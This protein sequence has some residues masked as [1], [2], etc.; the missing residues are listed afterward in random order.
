MTQA[1]ENLKR[2]LIRKDE[3]HSTQ[4]D[5]EKIQTTRSLIIGIAHEVNTP[6]G[7]ALTAASHA[8]LKIAD[9][10]SWLEKGTSFSKT[11]LEKHLGTINEGLALNVGNLH[12]ASILLDRFK[13]VDTNVHQEQPSRVSL[14]QFFSDLE[15]ALS[16]IVE[17]HSI[18]VY[19]TGDSIQIQ[20]VALWRVLMQLVENS[21]IHGFSEQ[22]N[23]LINI[24]A[25]VENECLII[26]Y[27]D[28][29]CGIP[30]DVGDKIFEPFYVNSRAQ[31]SLGL[32]LNVV[33]NL[34]KHNLHGAIRQ[35]KAPVGAR[36][37]IIIP[38]DDEKEN[39]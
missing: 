31:N 13:E 15:Q 29:G 20:Q 16:G 1:N 33:L 10:L 38:L 34:V 4:I 32:G 14:T 35:R 21:V 7:A 36:F 22:E 30:E 12:R 6:V 24:N 23:G 11:K 25:G 26:N 3:S 39:Q 18:A 28:N 2:P 8:Q 37:E 17:N 27:Q 19:T 9:V 5:L